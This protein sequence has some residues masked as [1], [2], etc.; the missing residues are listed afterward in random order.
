MRRRSARIAT[1]RQQTEAAFYQYAFTPEGMASLL[2]QLG[3][4]ILHIRPYASLDTLV[5]YGGWRMPAVLR[6]IAA[7]PLD[8][9]PVVRN[10]GS[11]CI[12]VARKC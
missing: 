7:L 4:E 8:Y 11:T 3:F 1:S 9:L 12:W 6:N 5:R 2:C 10:W